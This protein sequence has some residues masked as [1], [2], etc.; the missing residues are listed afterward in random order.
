MSMLS[1]HLTT[2]A[3]STNHQES[4]AATTTYS[5]GA[6]RHICSNANLFTTMRAIQHSTVTLPNHT[7]IA[8]A[9]SGDIKLCD[10]LILKDVLYVPQFKFNL[11]SVIALTKG[12]QFTI[13]FFPDCFVI[14]EI[15]SKKTIGK[16]DKLEDLYVLDTTT[17][18]SQSI[19]YVNSVF[20]RVWHN[21]LVSSENLLDLVLPHSGLDVP[22][23]LFVSPSS[24]VTQEEFEALDF[25]QDIQV[26]PLPDTPATSAVI[27]AR[28]STRHIK[29]PSYLLD[30]HCS[31]VSHKTLPDSTSSYPLSKFLSYNSLSASH[32]AF[33]L[34][35]SSHFEPQ[36]FHQ[37]VRF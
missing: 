31:L 32:R 24:S 10:N 21:R 6:T 1:T 14:Q 4:S 3:S 8:I 7:R 22:P 27:H 13:S 12:S 9:F 5:A 30:Y 35:I 19:A 23:A 28:K 11:M 17:L 37:A 36:F 15:N 29:P 26:A 25:V 33:V 16:G 2:F 18:K 34:A 20:A